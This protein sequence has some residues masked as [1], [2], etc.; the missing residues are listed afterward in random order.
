MDND[1]S[2]LLCTPNTNKKVRFPFF[3]LPEST[4]SASRNYELQ[5]RSAKD[6]ESGLFTPPPTGQTVGFEEEAGF[7]TPIDH[8]NWESE[9]SPISRNRDSSGQTLDVSSGDLRMTTPQHNQ[10]GNIE[11]IDSMLTELKDIIHQS[12]KKQTERRRSSS[13]RRRSADRD[14]LVDALTRQQEP[15]GNDSEWPVS[16]PCEQSVDAA[17]TSPQRS[18]TPPNESSALSSGITFHDDSDDVS[19]ATK[20]VNE[21]SNNF[22]QRIRDVAHKR[23]LSMTRS[24]D[25]L[26]AM[27]KGKLQP[28]DE[29]A[30][31][32]ADAIADADTDTNV[33]AV[34]KE[35]MQN[36]DEAVAQY[37]DTETYTGTTDHADIDG[38]GEDE[39]IVDD[40][41]ESSQLA[42]K[43][44]KSTSNQDLNR[45][46]TEFHFKARPLPE[47]TGMKGVGGLNGIPK[48]AKRPITTPF[49]PLLG[50]RRPDKVSVKALNAPKKTMPGP[51]NEE[52]AKR[53][54]ITECPKTPPPETP[55]QSI[56]KARPMPS[57]VGRK[58]QGGL[59]GVPKVQK[60]PL[61]VPKSP[62][63]GVRR[64]LSGNEMKP[65]F[66]GWKKAVEEGSLQSAGG[67]SSFISRGSDLQGLVV[68]GSPQ[69]TLDDRHIANDENQIPRA[70]HNMAFQPQS[71]VR[72]KQRADYNERRDENMKRKKEQDFKTRQREVRKMEKELIALRT[73]I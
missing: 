49:S 1:E 19:S 37:A 35:K 6:E 11:D 73:K 22:I 8:S 12:Q 10:G 61:T 60:R 43:P 44:R 33:K 39:S 46:A 68:L 21:S 41:T 26:R 14:F 56:F 66:C 9:I 54:S 2:L 48:V 17:P 45:S 65:Q 53:N 63:L 57:F 71:T 34:P 50:A 3:D 40:T 25:N 28:Y 47:T 24:R 30:G 36:Y 62:M 32:H 67:S 5:G 23:K 7:S 38:D 70:H 4:N 16:P 31:D 15:G 72:A 18:T 13:S 59:T 69:N 42:P 52:K 29:D 58:G 27:Q 51:K 20:K 64:S 55:T